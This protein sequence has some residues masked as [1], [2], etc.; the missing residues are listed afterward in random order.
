[1]EY[2]GHDVRIGQQ[3]EGGCDA[4]MGSVRHPHIPTGMEG[5]AGLCAGAQ[6]ATR[7]GTSMQP[8]KGK[9]R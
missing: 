2:E 4:C 9:G 8:I 1:M 5:S 7:G 6:A 3:A